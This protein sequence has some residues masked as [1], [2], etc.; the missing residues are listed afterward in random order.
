MV[1]YTYSSLGTAGTVAASDALVNDHILTITGAPTFDVRQ[2]EHMSITTPSAVTQGSITVTPT[3]PAASTEYSVQ[4]T[5]I[6]N[7]QQKQVVLST[8]TSASVYTAISICDAWKAQ[9]APQ[10]TAGILDITAPTTGTGTLIIQ[11][12]T[13]NPVVNVTQVYMGGGNVN[14]FT[15]AI[16]SGAMTFS[17]GNTS[18]SVA[19]GTYAALTAQGITTTPAL[20]S[21]QTYDQ[22][23]IQ[24]RQSSVSEAAGDVPQSRN[25]HTVLLYHS[26]TGYG[27]LSQRLTRI[28][29]GLDPATGLVADHE[30]LSLI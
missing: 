3:T 26:A 13:T 22:I 19:V 23:R 4:I 15:P 1:N 14:G 7:G 20:V 17:P 10:I 6:V 8:V 28:I 11:G 27:A 30:F 29:N 9:L 18:G 2:I 21:G 16:P 25:V 5:Q 12:S 24:Y